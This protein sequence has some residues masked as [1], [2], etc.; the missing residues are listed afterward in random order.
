MADAVVIQVAG[1]TAGIAVAED[2]GYRFFASSRPFFKL[3]K[4]L[5]RSVPAVLSAVRRL[6]ESRKHCRCPEERRAA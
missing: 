4:S 1:E 6:A 5:H 3:D 2:G